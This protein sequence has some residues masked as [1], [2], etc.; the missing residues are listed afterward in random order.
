MDSNYN[1][2]FEIRIYSSSRYCLYATSQ[3]LLQLF[4]CKELTK[5]TVKTTLTSSLSGK[6][7]IE[8]NFTK[9]EKRCL[10]AKPEP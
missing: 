6:S 5:K 3:E 2:G 4:Y 1:T 10:C 8:L 7:K 9:R